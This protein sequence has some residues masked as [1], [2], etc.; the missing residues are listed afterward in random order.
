MVQKQELANF[1]IITEAQNILEIFPRV[2]RMVMEAF[3]IK[4]ENWCSPEN[5]ILEIFTTE[6]FFQLMVIL[7]MLSNADKN[8][9]VVR[10]AQEGYIEELS[11][12]FYLDT[13]LLK[14]SKSVLSET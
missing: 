11:T 5:G 2:L 10:N 4:M 6:I 1:I 13:A 9:W 8:Y 3:S 12:R 14:S 7:F